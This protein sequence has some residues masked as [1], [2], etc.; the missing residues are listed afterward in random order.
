VEA[1]YVIQPLPVRVMTGRRSSPDRIHVFGLSRHY[2]EVVIKA[3][4]SRLLVVGRNMILLQKTLDI[5]AQSFGYTG[6]I[7]RVGLVEVIDLAFLD[8]ERN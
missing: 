2:S 5:E 7:L 8:V 4:S 6:A 3:R 1:V